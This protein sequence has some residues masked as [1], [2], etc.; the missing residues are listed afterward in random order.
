MQLLGFY[1]ADYVV[2]TTNCIQHSMD[3]TQGM[4]MVFTSCFRDFGNH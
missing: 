4:H 3:C 2:Y 1:L